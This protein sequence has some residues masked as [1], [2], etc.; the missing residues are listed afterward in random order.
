MKNKRIKSGIIII[1][2]AFM[3]VLSLFAGQGA[4]SAF[5]DTSNGSSVIKDLTADKNFNFADYPE[6]I[7][8]HSINVIQL[9]ES[10]ESD[11]FIYTYQPSGN[12]LNLRATTIRLST[13][14]GDDIKPRDYKLTFLS[15][16]D[17]LFKYKVEGLKVKADNVRYYDLTAIYRKWI[18]DIDDKTGNDN[19]INEVVYEV[20]QLWTVK[21]ENGTV[22]YHRTASET[23]TITDKYVDFLRYTEGYWLWRDACDSHYVA[24]SAD[25]DIEK[26]YEAELYYVSRSAI[27]F[28]SAWSE[29]YK[30][31][32]KIT[33]KVLLSEFDTG[34][35]TVTGLGGYKHTWSRIQSVAEFKEKEKLTE[36]IERNLDGKQ[37]VLRFADTDFEHHID[38]SGYSGYTDFYT[39]VSEVTILRLKFETD[40]KVYNLGVVDNKQTGDEIPGNEF[41]SDS[42]NFWRYVWNCILKLFK[43]EASF[44]EGAV[45]VVALFICFMLLPALIIVLSV[46]FPT[47]GAVVKTILKGIW[48]VIC[49]PFRG[50]A[51]LFGKGGE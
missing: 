1:V 40:G 15:S 44:V 10:V 11:I 41:E 26:L 37:W 21:T 51:K 47:F 32:D 4:T 24:F 42:F 48:W 28:N 9:A 27:H 12:K 22:N 7:D 3:L 31:G 38:M 6:E 46:L 50:I 14:T 43:G 16:W 13:E 25:Y 29:S 45:A 17:T 36:E 5:A 20:A 39:E 35:T 18:K 23:I 30:Y 19:E 34:H 2:F 8:D 49:L 33:N